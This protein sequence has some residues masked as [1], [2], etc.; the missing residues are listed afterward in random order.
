MYCLQKGLAVVAI[1][2]NSVVTHPQVCVFLCDSFSSVQMSMLVVVNEV[3]TRLFFCYF[4][5]MGRSS[6]Q[7]MPKCSS[8][9]FLTCMMR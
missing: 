7:K 9:R 4:G 2:S 1:S 6:W 3:S 5:R 8:T